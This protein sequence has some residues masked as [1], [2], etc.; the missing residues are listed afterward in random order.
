P[1]WHP[2]SDAIKVACKAAA[3]YCKQNG[4]NISKLAL[5]YSLSNKDLSTVLVGMNSVKQVKENVSAALEL[6]TA[7]IDDDTLSKVEEILK[8]VKN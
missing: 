4:K 7:G 8:P 3:E 6:Q 2:A 1:D 5:Q